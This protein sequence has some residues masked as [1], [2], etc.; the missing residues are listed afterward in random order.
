VIRQPFVSRQARS[1]MGYA[2]PILAALLLSGCSMLGAGARVETLEQALAKVEATVQTQ[3]EANA[4][5]TARVG[6][7]ESNVNLKIGGGGDTIGSWLSIV[8]AYA[9]AA[10]S[11]PGSRWIRRKWFWQEAQTAA[12]IGEPAQV[13][14]IGDKTE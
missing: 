6:T 2:F 3:T 10:L 9:L 14:S 8:G 11:Y 7:I 12:T 1:R 4:N 5:L 13:I